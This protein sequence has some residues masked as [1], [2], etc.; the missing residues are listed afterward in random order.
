[1]SNIKSVI[2]L[3]CRHLNI[4]F[5]LDVK[6][7]HFRLS[8]FN[9]T[10]NNCVCH[11][12]QVLY[13]ACNDIYPDHKEDDVVR[14]VKLSF[15]ALE[16]KNIDF[17]CLPSDMSS[18][19]RELL[20]ALGWLL[21]VENLLEKSTEKKLRDSSMNMEFDVQTIQKEAV[22]SQIVPKTGSLRSN[23]NCI[24]LMA[25]K[26]RHNVNAI[27]EL[28]QA[29]VAFTNKVHEGSSKSCGLSHLSVSES[30]LVRYPH[31]LPEYLKTVSETS[32]LIETHQQWQKKCHLFWEWMGTVAAEKECAIKVNRLGVDEKK[33]L[34]SV[35]TS[36]R[37]Q[38][39]SFL[40]QRQKKKNEDLK[41]VVQGAP[42]C[43]LE[44]KGKGVQ[45]DQLILDSEQQLS[46]V[47]NIHDMKKADIASQFHVLSNEIQNAIVLFPQF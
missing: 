2:S 4:S 36:L 46:E 24:L 8:K 1:M 42:R 35:L 41:S 14:F 12:W 7:E 20:L 18:G 25:G 31:L 27:A 44:T 3:L 9:K 29:R 16:Y 21:L 10:E 38:A 43:V 11:M 23:V 45:M 47:M 34:N 33:T 37:L 39:N 15:A 6:P 22:P 40:L 17:Y 26:I 19:S 30:K 28:D 5:N 32:A 13:K